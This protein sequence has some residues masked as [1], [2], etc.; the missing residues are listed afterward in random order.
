MLAAILKG[1]FTVIKCV[2]FFILSRFVSDNDSLK[3]IIISWYFEYTL[4]YSCDYCC[5]NAFVRCTKYKDLCSPGSRSESFHFMALR[6]QINVVYPEIDS[7]V[8]ELL[9]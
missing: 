5:V 8:N 4:L 7:Q 2:A 9:I 3:S 6:P 1:C